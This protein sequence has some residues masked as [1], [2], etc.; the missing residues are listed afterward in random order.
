MGI[1]AMARPSISAAVKPRKAWAI[2]HRSG[3]IQLDKVCPS[4]A[5][6]WGLLSDEHDDLSI[7]DMKRNG[8]RC[9]RVVIRA[10]FEQNE[11]L[12]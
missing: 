11:R 3:A 6:C 4:K 2:V 1:H 8:Y 5:E 9:I 12:A 7:A 10:A